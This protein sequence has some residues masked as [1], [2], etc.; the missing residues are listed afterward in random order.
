MAGLAAA[1]RD[2]Q[3]L[4]PEDGVHPHRW[5]ARPVGHAA[6]VELAEQGLE[7]LTLDA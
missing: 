6:A 3:S 1:I 5:T 4:R 2:G 7:R